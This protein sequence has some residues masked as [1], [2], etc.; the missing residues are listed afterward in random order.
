M[1]THFHGPKTK[2]GGD[3]WDL[4]LVLC[5]KSNTGL[6]VKVGLNTIKALKPEWRL[7]PGLDL[8]YIMHVYLIAMERTQQLF[9]WKV[10]LVFVNGSEFDAMF[11]RRVNP[12]EHIFF[13][14][15]HMQCQGVTEPVCRKVLSTLSRKHW[16]DRCA[17]LTSVSGGKSIPSLPP[18]ECG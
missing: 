5:G 16:A 18:R 1:F 12:A 11:L 9:T 8:P 3:C 13:E 15:V 17:W 2:H 10:P 6:K 14:S 7:S 4:T